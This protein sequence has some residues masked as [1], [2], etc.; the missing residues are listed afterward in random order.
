MNELSSPEQLNAGSRWNRWEPHIHAPGTVFNNQFKGPNAWT[1]YLTSL[2]QATPIIRA[3][4]VT[5]YYLYGLVST[6]FARKSRER[7]PS[8]SGPCLPEC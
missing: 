3:I 8:P 6:G 5:D 7:S 4:A 1:N 2:E